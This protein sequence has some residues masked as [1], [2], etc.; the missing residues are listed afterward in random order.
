M[1]SF[2]EISPPVPEKIFE[3]FLI[4]MGK[5]AILVML[6]IKFGFVWPSGFRGEDVFE[7][8]GDIHE[9]CP[10]VGAYEVLGSF[11]FRIISIQSYCPFPARLSF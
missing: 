4:Y 5:E 2:V 9:Y 1:P 3:G 10:G 11:F 7:Y 8:I 6:H